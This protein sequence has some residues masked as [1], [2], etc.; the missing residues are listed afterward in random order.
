MHNSIYQKAARRENTE[1][2]PPIWLMRQAGRYMP[3]YR[4]LRESYSFMELMRTPELAAEVTMQPITAFGMDAAIMFSDILITADAL[5]VGLHFEEG[6]GPVIARPVRTAGD[7]A[8]LPD[9]DASV[10][11]GCV[12]KEISLLRPQLDVLGV[13]LI[14]FAGAPFTVASYMVEGGSSKTLSVIKGMLREAP[15]AF[16]ALLARLEQVT[17][18]YLCVQIDAGVHAVQL[19]DTWANYLD[20]G[21]FRQHSLAPM[22]RIISG[23]RAHM[24][25]VGKDVPISVFCKNSRVFAPEL[26]AIKPDIISLDSDVTLWEMR[27]KLGPNIAL[28]GNL[29]PELLPGDS[30][31]LLEAA[32]TILNRMGKDPG[33]I[34]NLGHGVTPQVP[35]ENVRQL[36]NLVQGH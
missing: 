12:A 27:E 13:P 21:E 35:V 4:K 31:P 33:F 16:S 11:F 3:E 29:D 10:A 22:G 26:M 24:K 9:V 8:A 30:T 6:R 36:V 15:E 19:F 34:F 1:G 5:G 17:I 28:Q 25:T 2:R 7:V 18:D 14:G 20:L 32:H 23:L